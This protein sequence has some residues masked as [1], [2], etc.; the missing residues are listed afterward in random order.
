M[1]W[2]QNFSDFK[3]PFYIYSLRQGD[4]ITYTSQTP[5]NQCFIIIHG[6]AYLTKIFKNKK[7]IVLGVFEKNNIIK[8]NET[9]DYYNYNIVAIEQTFIISF[10]W[11]NIIKRQHVKFYF[12]NDIIKSYHMTLYNYEAMSNI[13][14]HKST[15]QRVIQLVFF[16]VKNFLL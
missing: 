3:V 9:I 6:V 15:K 14:A 11:N 5:Y 2:I 13:L 8:G 16:Y 10:N 7:L 1:K 4:Y 12:L